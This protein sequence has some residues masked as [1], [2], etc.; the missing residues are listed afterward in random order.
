MPVIDHIPGA[1][2]LTGLFGIGDKP[3]AGAAFSA[4]KAAP[5]AN[6]VVGARV[7]KS[8]I[9]GDMTAWQ[10][11]KKA[12]GSFARTMLKGE[13]RSMFLGSLGSTELGQIM[14][15]TYTTIRGFD[16]MSGQK[17]NGAISPG[18]AGMNAGYLLQNAFRQITGKTAG[19]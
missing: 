2:A 15:T 8:K 11:F 3:A 18:A 4:A 17:K 9:A 12:E 14:A 10:G 16:K 7:N 6:N 13:G 19:G 1:H 5:A